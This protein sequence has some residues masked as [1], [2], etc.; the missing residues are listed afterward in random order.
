MIFSKTLVV[1]S[2]NFAYTSIV[3]STTS[4]LE[5]LGFDIPFLTLFPFSIAS[6]SN[7]NDVDSF[8]LSTEGLLV[9]PFY[10]GDSFNCSRWVGLL[11]LLLLFCLGLAIIAC[12]STTTLLSLDRDL[13]LVVIG[14]FGFSTK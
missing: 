10:I 3:A 12:T 8:C 9:S 11:I 2:K 13:F 1:I 6:I 4:S 5:I 7:S 14:L